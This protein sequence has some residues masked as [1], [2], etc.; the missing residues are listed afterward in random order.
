VTSLTLRAATPV[1]PYHHRRLLSLPP[2]NPIIWRGMADGET[3]ASGL[4][5]KL[6]GL[7]AAGGSGDGDDEKQQPASGEEPQLSKK[8]VS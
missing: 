8:C 3:S 5:E 4:V 7:S 6:A 1:K 2:R